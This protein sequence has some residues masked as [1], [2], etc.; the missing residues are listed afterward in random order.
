MQFEEAEELCGQVFLNFMRRFFEYAK[1]K[2]QKNYMHVARDKTISVSDVKQENDDI[3]N[4]DQNILQSKEPEA[5]QDQ[6][7]PIL[8]KGVF[9]V[10]TERTNEESAAPSEMRDPVRISKQT[11]ASANIDSGRVKIETSVKSEGTGEKN[12]SKNMSPVDVKSFKAYDEISGKDLQSEGVPKLHFSQSQKPAINIPDRVEAILNEKPMRA[13]S[14]DLRVDKHR[15]RSHSPEAVHGH[16]H[17][18]SQSQYSSSVARQEF[19][20]KK[21]KEQEE[22]KESGFLT[23]L[24]KLSGRE[25]GGDVE[26]D[27]SKELEKHLHWVDTNKQAAAFFGDDIIVNGKAIKPKTSDSKLQRLEVKE[28]LERGFVNTTQ[29]SRPNLSPKNSSRVRDSHFEAEKNERI[30]EDNASYEKA[31]R[32]KDSNSKKELKYKHI[33][34]QSDRSDVKELPTTE[35]VL[36][37]EKVVQS[38]NDDI[39]MPVKMPVGSVPTNPS[40]KSLYRPGKDPEPRR[41]SPSPASHHEFELQKPVSFKKA[42]PELQKIPLKSSKPT[43]TSNKVRTANSKTKEVSVEKELVKKEKTPSKKLKFSPVHSE[44]SSKPHHVHP[45]EETAPKA[46]PPQSKTIPQPKSNNPSDMKPTP[47]KKPSKIVVTPEP[48]IQKEIPSK[49]KETSKPPEKPHLPTSGAKLTEVQK[50]KEVKYNSKT[51]TEPHQQGAPK[52]EEK[53]KDSNPIQTKPTAATGQ[54]ASRDQKKKRNELRLHRKEPLVFPP[55]APKMQHP[56]V[57]ASRKQNL[58]SL[59]DAIPH[60]PPPAS[61]TPPRKPSYEDDNYRVIKVDRS[62]EMVRSSSSKNSKSNFHDKCIQ[63]AKSGQGTKSK[64]KSPQPSHSKGKPSPLTSKVQSPQIPSSAA[65]KRKSIHFQAMRRERSKSMEIK[66]DAVPVTTSL[67]SG[68]K[69]S[70]ISTG[71]P[72]MISSGQPS[73]IQKEGSPSRLK[74]PRRYPS[75]DLKQRSADNVEN[76]HPTKTANSK[77]HQEEKGKRSSHQKH[78]MNLIETGEFDDPDFSSNTSEV[79]QKF[80]SMINNLNIK[81]IE[82]LK[83]EINL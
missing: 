70:P 74:S 53:K 24:R 62:K 58:H 29:N 75:Q 5:D 27:Y 26:S 51:N 21:C 16:S 3:L 60:P 77:R 32:N 82:D 46:I 83:Q 41:A 31:S 10:I 12:D 4:D 57:K 73:E 47:P 37:V 45:K 80:D 6:Q 35:V 43:P 23:D 72:K 38:E 69:N 28:E 19:K 66:Y 71:K 79:R 40:L 39:G 11:L 63:E 14:A 61:K 34:A 64:E 49:K 52:Q 30:L 55:D 7:H 13:P 25:Y 33:E 54:E 42:K 8:K 44:A 17:V 65:N 20:L 15:S 56:K 76:N 2:N 78:P 59:K 22:K 68:N 1:Q 36:K 50:P 48:T 67:E 9:S 18:S 81:F